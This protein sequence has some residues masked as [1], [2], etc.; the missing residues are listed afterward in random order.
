M[1]FAPRI[2]AYALKS[3]VRSQI[4]EDRIDEHEQMLPY[5]VAALENILGPDLSV[6]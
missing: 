6:L 3:V 2:S 4:V 5:D 1:P